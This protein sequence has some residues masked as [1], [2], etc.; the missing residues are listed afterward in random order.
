MLVTEF[1]N[2]PDFNHLKGIL[3]VE[4]F[5]IGKL[6]EFKSRIDNGEISDVVFSNRVTASE[7]LQLRIF[8]KSKVVKCSFGLHSLEN[9]KR[10]EKLAFDLGFKDLN[11]MLFHSH[12]HIKVSGHMQYANLYVCWF[13]GHSADKLYFS[14]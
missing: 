7:A 10:V 14:Q 12:S 9:T 5:F 8:P 4:P 1:M 6:V 13:D 3:C 11:S 2:V